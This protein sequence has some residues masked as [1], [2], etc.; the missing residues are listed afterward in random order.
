M[1]LH[2]SYLP[3]PGVQEIPILF[4]VSFAVGNVKAISAL[5]ASKLKVF[6]ELVF[7]PK[8]RKSV[9]PETNRSLRPSEQIHDL[10]DKNGR[11]LRKCYCV[12]FL[13]KLEN[14]QNGVGL[15]SSA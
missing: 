15:E 3:C 2:N 7:I 12:C 14:I 11:A 8:Q 6:E 10:C 1:T 4:S 5:G 13:Y 9:S